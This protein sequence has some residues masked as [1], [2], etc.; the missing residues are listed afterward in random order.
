MSMSNEKLLNM[1]E[2]MCYLTVLVLSLSDNLKAFA[3]SNTF[4]PYDAAIALHKPRKDDSFWLNVQTEYARSKT[5]LNWIGNRC[6][7]L[8]LYD[9][10]E[11]M[12]LML[13]RPVGVR[14]APAQ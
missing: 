3:K 1:V 2:K 5:G 12:I 8:Q 10:A 13:E 6:N 9:D 14:T 4:R 7:V 11:S